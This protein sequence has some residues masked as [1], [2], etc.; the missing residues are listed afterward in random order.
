MQFIQIIAILALLILV[1]EFGHFIFARIFGIRV[2]K[3]FL[4]FDAGG[5]KLF[6]TKAKWFLKLC[7]KAEKWE[8]EYGIGWLPFGGYCKICGMV[9]ESLDTENLQNEPQPWE[10]RA[11]PAWKRLLVMFGGVLFNFILGIVLFWVFLGNWGRLYETTDNCLYVEENSVAYELGFRTGD[12]VLALDGTSPQYIYMLQPSIA[13]DGVK[14]VTVVR[15]NDTIN[16][17]MDHGKLPDLLN[18][19]SAFTAALEFVIGQVD[20]SQAGKNA[21]ILQPGDRVISIDGEPNKYLQTASPVLKAK[22]GQDVEV[23][24]VRGEDTITRTLHV[25]EEGMLGVGVI[26]TRMMEYQQYNGWEIIPAGIKEAYNAVIN[27]IK[28]LKLLLNPETGAYKSVGSVITVATQMPDNW[29]WAVIIYM[30][31]LL[32]IILGVMNLLPI[33]ALDGGHIIFTLYEIVTRR[34]PSVKFLMVAQLIGMFLLFG[35]MFLAL[36]N[37][38]LR[39]LN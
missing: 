37:D 25:N 2:E 15:D 1:H 33:P 26:D 8:T 18:T 39:L 24:I 7:P 34:K 20:R 32:S 35:L 13:R 21:D 17:Y 11:K 10:F 12:K 30:S 36:G 9:D 38:I 4:F 29:H 14:K 16:L 27:Q 5:I 22:A 19:N 6:S 31:A 23:G 3:F 28:D